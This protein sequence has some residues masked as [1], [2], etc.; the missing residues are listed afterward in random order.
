MR[1]IQIL[2]A[3]WKDILLRVK[4]KIG[5][6][7]VSLI[8]AGIAFYAF[9]AVF[10]A[11]ATGISLYGLRYDP[12]E[13][14]RQLATLEGFL[15]PEVLGLLE[16]QLVRVAD[17][18][19]ALGLGMVFGILLTIWSASRG[20]K[21]LITALNIVYGET[22]RRSFVR[23]NLVGLFFTFCAIVFGIASLGLIIAL[24]VV[25]SA[26]GLSH[27][28]PV[29]ANAL[30]W[31]LLGIV[32]V[33]GLGLLYRFAPHRK[34]AKLH[35]ATWGSVAAALM[36]LVA[37]ILFSLYISH[38]GDYNATYGS[39]GA[40]VILLLWFYVGAYAVLLGGELN[41][42]MEHQTAKD[43]TTQPPRLMGKRGAQ[44]ADAPGEKAGG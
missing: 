24:P 12:A 22:E 23:F 40:A 16:N 34:T 19:Q 39:L 28:D 26:L 1:P 11:I 15:P 43:S 13:I 32:I 41:S 10:P 44:V 30:R 42:E 4:S 27:L 29:W 14:E 37:S 33:L 31:V 3:G 7:S 9:V 35:W 36:W 21:A 38:F 2:L 5:K 20:M 25:L 18:E 6:D 8:S 17:A